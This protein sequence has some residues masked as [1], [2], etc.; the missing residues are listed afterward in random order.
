[1]CC[2]SQGPRAFGREWRLRFHRRHGFP[3]TSMSNKSPFGSA[4]HFANMG[5]WKAGSNTSNS[6]K[7][8]TQFRQFFIA[9]W[10]LLL[11]GNMGPTFARCHNKWP[12]RPQTKNYNR[13][14]TVTGMRLAWVW[15]A[16]IERGQQILGTENWRRKI[17][18]IRHWF[19]T[20][21]AKR[22]SSWI[23]TPDSI[24]HPY[25]L[26]DLFMSWIPGIWWEWIPST[27]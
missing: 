17:I 16:W 10:R 13:N 24:I 2:R 9:S 15:V 6:Q 3:L 14:F 11:H 8:K 25:R 19:T 1:M 20:H 12:W 22:C 23:V 4:S 5:S 27:N 26:S 18:R 7:L 21:R